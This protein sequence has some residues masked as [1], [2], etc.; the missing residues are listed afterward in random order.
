MTK[1]THR[2]LFNYNV[3]CQSKIDTKPFIAQLS[4]KVGEKKPLYQYLWLLC[5]LY[6][7]TKC[8]S[9]FDLIWPF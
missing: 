2:Y 7:A 8:S 3:Q 9:Y 4:K 1:I 6:T 5:P